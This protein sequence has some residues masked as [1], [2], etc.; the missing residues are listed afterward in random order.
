MRQI[1]FILIILYIL[2]LP[3]MVFAQTTTEPTTTEPFDILK[4]GQTYLEEKQKEIE[5]G[6][7]KE[8]EKETEQAWQRIKE[9]IKEGIRNQIKNLIKQLKTY[10]I[11]LLEEIKNKVSPYIPW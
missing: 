6:I 1:K 2:S 8:I 10:L 3:L 4:K 11:N 5:Q 7:K 9:S